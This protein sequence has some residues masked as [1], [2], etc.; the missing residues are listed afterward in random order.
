MDPQHKTLA[1]GRWKSLTLLEQ[2]GNIGSEISR[3]IRWKEKDALLYEKAFYRALE[4]IDLT[5]ADS[6]W[7]HRLKEVARLRELLCRNY[8]EE[9]TFKTDF[10]TL[11]DYCTSFALAARASK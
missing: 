3:A 4:L 6:R 2:L 1:E 10:A 11:N 9:Q 5:L 8:M 7:N